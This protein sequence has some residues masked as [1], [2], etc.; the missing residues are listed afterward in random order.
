L[1][2]DTF[3]RHLDGTE[4]IGVYPIVTTASGDLCIWGCIDIDTDDLDGARNLQTILKA[5]NITTFVERTRKGYHVWCFAESLVLA[6]TMRRALLAA[7]QTLNYP[8]KEVNPKQERLARGQVGNYVRL[9]YYGPQEGVPVDRFVMDDNDN[10]LDLGGFL[11]T[12]RKTSV[13]ALEETA[14]LWV[15]PPV[16]QYTGGEAVWGQDTHDLIAP[17]M[18]SDDVN[19]TVYS[20]WRH[21]PMPDHPDRSGALV[22]LAFHLCECHI[23]IEQAWLVLIDADRRWGK[24]HARTDGEYQ[25]RRILE[26]GYRGS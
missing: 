12:V 22:R 10:P 15:A 6:S 16:T 21:G 1:T 19:G 25:L 11:A 4:K 5:R 9:P 3:K 17:L 8:A 7:H 18:R 26:H 20:I 24:F 13:A 2:V 14:S 23:P